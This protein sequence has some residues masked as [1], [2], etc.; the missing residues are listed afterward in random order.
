MPNGPIHEYW[1]IKQSGLPCSRTHRAIDSWSQVIGSK[2]RI[3]FHT[4]LEAMIVAD[5]VDGPH[6]RVAALN[7]LAIDQIYDDPDSKI[8]F[9]IS[10]LTDTA[11]VTPDPDSP[12]ETVRAFMGFRQQRRRR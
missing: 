7:H 9:E 10:R 6:C 3:Y 5:L 8:F 4:P 2:H 11:P 1:S 12:H